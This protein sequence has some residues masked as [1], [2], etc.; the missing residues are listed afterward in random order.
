MS[1]NSLLSAPATGTVYRI[2][3]AIFLATS[4]YLHAEL[5]L[6][7]YRTI[8]G[9]GP[10]FLLQASGSFAVAALLVLAAPTILLLGAAALSAGALAGFVLSRTVGVLGF[11]EHGFSPAPQAALSVIAETATLAL[12]VVTQQLDVPVRSV[13]PDPLPVLDQS[14][15]VLHPDHRG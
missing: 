9:I 4:G 15:G 5:Y 12:L 10:A 1:G 7:G 8:P 6:G 3:T 13:H 11:I 2:A 14:G